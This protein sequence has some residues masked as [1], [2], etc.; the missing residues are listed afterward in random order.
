M[1]SFKYRGI[2]NRIPIKDVR[3]IQFKSTYEDVKRQ[4]NSCKNIIKMLEKDRDIY[5]LNIWKEKLAKAEN[6]LEAFD[7]FISL[8]PN[9]IKE[10]KEMNKNYPK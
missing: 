5:H 9:V 3:I 2:D 8:F 7:F 1:N 10:T 6:T 4:I